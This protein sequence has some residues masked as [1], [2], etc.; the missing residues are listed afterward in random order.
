MKKLL[1]IIV[2][3]SISMG[4]FAQRYSGAKNINLSGGYNFENGYIIS[5][6]FEKYFG[7]T[8]SLRINA[9]YFKSKDEIESLSTKIDINNILADATFNYYLP[10]YKK[11]FF[12][13][14]AG[15]TGGYQFFTFD[16]P[17]YVEKTEDN[18]FVYGFNGVGQIELNISSVSIFTEYKATYLFNSREKF[19]HYVAFGLKKYF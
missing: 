3:A 10:L 5:A 9:Q 15:G 14:G 19:N 8:H 2:F 17:D 16:K 11:L 18:R 4:V 6:G 12:S 1:I 7:Y 13:I